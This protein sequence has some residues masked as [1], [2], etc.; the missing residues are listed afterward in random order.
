MVM[1]GVVLFEGLSGMWA[2]AKR[3]W[4]STPCKYLGKDHSKQRNSKR[5]DPEMGVHLARLRNKEANKA[6]GPREGVMEEVRAV[7]RN[8]RHRTL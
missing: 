7:A 6:G 5:Q 1:S 8:K 4:R 3:E 2:D